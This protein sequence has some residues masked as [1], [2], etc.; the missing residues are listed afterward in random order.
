MEGPGH[1]LLWFHTIVIDVVHHLASYI[2]ADRGALVLSLIPS[3]T[4]FTP[5]PCLKC[6][7]LTW[8]VIWFWGIEEL[9]K[10]ELYRPLYFLSVI[11]LRCT[12]DSCR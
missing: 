3:Y 12:S 2:S 8:A 11:G 7:V 4:L 6:P 5:A 1:P 10:G 9:I